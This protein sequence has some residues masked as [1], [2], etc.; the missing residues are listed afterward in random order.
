MKGILGYPLQ[1]LYS[2]DAAELFH[3]AVVS[4][5][6]AW[7]REVSPT[8]LLCT[9]IAVGKVSSETPAAFDQEQ[10]FSK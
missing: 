1:T 8:D 10:K 3:T 7:S 9:F 4:S 5:N 6:L 2:L